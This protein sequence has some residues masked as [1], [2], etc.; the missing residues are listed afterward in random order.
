MTPRAWVLLL[1]LLPRLVGLR[2]GLLAVLGEESQHGEALGEDATLRDAVA[3]EDP[4]GL[5]C[6]D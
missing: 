1:E 6:F 4:A 5:R 3:A 2:E